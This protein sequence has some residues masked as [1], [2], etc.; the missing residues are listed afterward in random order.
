MVARL[1]AAIPDSFS[2]ALSQHRFFAHEYDYHIPAKRG[3]WL[4]SR[5]VAP[6][7]LGK[8]AAS[9]TGFIYVGEFGFLLNTID[10]RRWEFAFLRRHGLKIAC[11]FAGSDIRDRKS[12]V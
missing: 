5:F 4:R 12:V 10:D 3:D 2:V 7:L 9:A 11:V 1:A 8:L 6:W